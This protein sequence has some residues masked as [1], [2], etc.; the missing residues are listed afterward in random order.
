MRHSGTF[1]RIALNSV[2]SSPGEGNV[3]RKSEQLVRA[4]GRWSLAAVMINTILGAS[5]FGIPSLLAAHL[6]ALSVAGYWIAAVGVAVIAA[7]FAEVASQ[8][9]QAG[10]PYLYAGA[11]FGRFGAIQI[12]WLLYLSRLAAGAGVANVLIGY[13]GQFVSS[14]N[15]RFPRVLFLAILISFVAFI[16]YRGVTG[17]TRLS[18][19]FT[20]TKLGLLAVFIASGLA[21]RWIHPAIW[22]SPATTSP[23]TADWLDGLILMIYAYGGFESGFLVSGEARN[24]RRDAPVALLIAIVSVTLVYMGLQYVVIHTL[25]DAAASVKPAADAAQHFAGPLGA[26]LVAAWAVVSIYGY[27]TATMLLPPRLT[28]AMAESGDFPGWLAAVHPRFRTPHVSI[29]FFAL[30]LFAFS[31]AG[32]FRWNATLAALSRLLI[33]SSTAAALPI[34]RRKQPLADAFRLPAGNAFVVLALAFTAVLLTRIQRGAGVVL[35]VVLVLGTLNW[36]WARG[37]ASQVLERLPTVD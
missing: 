9:D 33:C 28:F 13:L 16:N 8:F 36:L 4:V 22:V 31:I 15:A 11:A 20:V 10:G 26:R 2:Q 14:A 24:V 34:L 32:S 35:A 7:T 37:R 21:I 18:N 23:T 17:G 27:F 1:N 6:G 30:L 25:P 3:P 12:G 29:L 19:F 5:V